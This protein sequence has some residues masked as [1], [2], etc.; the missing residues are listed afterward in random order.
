MSG[1]LTREKQTIRVMIGVDCHDHHH[2]DGD[3]CGECQ[4]LLEY[5]Y[6]KINGCPFHEVKPICADCRVHCYKGD[7]REGVRTVMRHSG[8]RMLLRHPRLAILHI[9]DR[10]R[11]PREKVR[12][13]RS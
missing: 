11:K 2:G 13:S 10:I 5:A 8:P 1:R 3:V 4:E 6:R 12:G 9:A 7:M